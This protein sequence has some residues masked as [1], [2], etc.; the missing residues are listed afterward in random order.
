MAFLSGAS[1]LTTNVS[2]STQVFARNLA[3]GSNYLVSVNTNGA[4]GNNFAGTF[5]ITSHGATI[6]PIAYRRSIMIF[7]IE[8]EEEIDGRW[9]AKV[10]Q[11]PGV[12]CYDQTADEAIAK[13]EVLA[14]RALGRA[15]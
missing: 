6:S 10:P 4:G 7:T 12:L 3:T 8:C 13:A 15:T 14:L 9:M 2:S 5:A 1:D 11:V